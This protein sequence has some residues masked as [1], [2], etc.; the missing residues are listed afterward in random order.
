MS[1]LE[2]SLYALDWSDY[3]G[4]SSGLLEMNHCAELRCFAVVIVTVIIY[5]YSR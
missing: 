1:G 3:I 2:E 4:G 5:D